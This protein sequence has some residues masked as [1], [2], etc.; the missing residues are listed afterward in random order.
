MPEVSSEKVL[1]KAD[2]I[3]AL[4]EFN[5]ESMPGLLVRTIRAL[6]YDAV[7]FTPGVEK[8]TAK[9]VDETFNL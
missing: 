7:I 9:T 8:K 4:E 2:R 1:A 6:G 5:N 3:A